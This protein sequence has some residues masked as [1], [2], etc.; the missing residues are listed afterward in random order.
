M[1]AEN[2]KM[3]DIFLFFQCRNISFRKSLRARLKNTAHN[4][5]GTSLWKFI[6]ESNLFRSCNRADVFP[7][8]LSQFFCKLFRRIESGPKDTICM[9]CR[10]LHLMRQA[11]C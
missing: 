1:M 5:A 11:D 6:D 8:V 3:E 4:L 2:S 9:D 10:T 7:N